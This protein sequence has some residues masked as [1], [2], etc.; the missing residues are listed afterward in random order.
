MDCFATVD[1]HAE[2]YY[3]ISPYV[4]CNDNPVNNIDANGDSITVTQEAL[5]TICAGLKE[6]E[7]L[8]MTVNNGLIDPESIKDQAENSDDLFL[9]DLF[10]I[11]SAEQVV[12]MSVGSSYKYK[13]NNE[14]T[15]DSNKDYHATPADQPETSPPPFRS[16]YDDRE[17]DGTWSVTG[18]TG[19][20]L[21]PGNN[22]PTG[23]NSTNNHIQVI[24][25]SNG[26]VRQR[27]VGAAHE[28]GHVVLYLR[29]GGKSYTHIHKGV[30]IE[31]GKRVRQMINKLYK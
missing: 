1:P 15:L 24:I 20:T 4:Y 31:I 28:F 13:N 19:R 10:E 22:N 16:I 23:A 7:K 6:G 26:T 29:S 8:H 9:Q 27:A 25:N 14:E 11:A 5:E 3:S 30:N 2:K 17:N 18:N 12:E 21:V